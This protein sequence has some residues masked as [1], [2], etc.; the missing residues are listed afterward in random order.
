MVN[1]YQQKYCLFYDNNP[2]LAY[3]DVNE[4]LDVEALID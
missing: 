4:N 2:M 3:Q 1:I